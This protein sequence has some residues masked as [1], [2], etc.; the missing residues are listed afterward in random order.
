MFAG[1]SAFNSDLSSWDVSSVTDMSDM[2]R[3]ADAFNGD[4]SSWDV[5]SVTDMSDMFSYADAFNQDLCAWA[6]IFPYSSAQDIFTGSGCTFDDTPQSDQ[7]GP[8][9]AS[10]SCTTTVRRREVNNNQQ[11]WI[12]V[13]DNS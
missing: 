6:D 5:S 3:G 4:L 11:S 10:S 2:F 1:A 8:F 7:R 13:G 12:V 9:C